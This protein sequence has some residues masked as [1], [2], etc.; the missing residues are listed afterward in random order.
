MPGETAVQSGG[1]AKDVAAAL[2]VL[3]YSPQEISAAMRKVDISALTVED[4]IREVLKTSL[5]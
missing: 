4:A 1:K 5:K 2:S 3:G